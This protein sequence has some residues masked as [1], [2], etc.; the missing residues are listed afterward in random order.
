ALMRHL[1]VGTREIEI[2]SLCLEEMRALGHRPFGI[3]LD[4]LTVETLAA[5]LGDVP[6]DKCNDLTFENVQARMRTSLLMNSGFV[7]GTGDLSEYALGWCTY[8]GDHISMYN[9]NVSIPK[10]LVKFLV[11]WAAESEF[12]GPAQKTLLDVVATQI[13][14]ELLP[15][16]ATGEIAQ[17]TESVIGPYELHDF[18]LF[19]FLRYG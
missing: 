2:R 18:F 3:A 6:A 14:P 10:T 15:A 4:G 5:K 17:M 13:S 16:A 12:S 19:H 9:P 7:V 8:N 1:G 11:R